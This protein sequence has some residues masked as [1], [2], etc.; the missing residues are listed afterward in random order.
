MNKKFSVIDLLLLAII[1]IPA[2]YLASVYPQMPATIPVHFG[3][4][5]ADGFGEKGESWLFI[6]IISGLSFGLTIFLKYLPAIDPKKTAAVSSSL[7][8]KISIVMVIFFAILQVIIINAMNGKMLSM[9]KFLIQFH[10][11]LALNSR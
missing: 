9:E 8:A 7:I 10:F 1:S 11:R 5:G 2:F 4:H 3:L 6:M